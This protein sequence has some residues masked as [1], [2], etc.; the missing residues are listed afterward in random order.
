M[1]QLESVATEIAEARAQLV[2]VAA[3]KRQGVFRPD[4][5]LATHPISFPFLLDEDRGVSRRYGVYQRLGSDAI[6]I[7]RPATFV[8]DRE[9]LL[10]FVYVSKNQR[11]RTEIEEVIALAATL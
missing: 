1:T 7:A 8:V 4:K 11:D 3:E 6:N 5:Y 2:Y 10:Q 9:G